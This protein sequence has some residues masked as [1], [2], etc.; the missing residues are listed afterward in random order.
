MQAAYRLSPRAA[1][2]ADLNW[3][4]GKNNRHRGSLHS[5]IWRGTAAELASRGAVAVYPAL[6]WWKTRP[7]LQRYDF[8]VRYAVLI[9]IRA[10]EVEV[11][12][13]TEVASQIGV[14]IMVET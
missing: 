9:S 8:P 7:H 1:R 12:L 14:P 6:G 2:G 3:L 4:L 5:D 10:P 11:D 13:A